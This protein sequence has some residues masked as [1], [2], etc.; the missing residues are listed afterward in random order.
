[1]VRSVYEKLKGQVEK[2]RRGSVFV[3]R[4]FLELGSRAAVDE[5]LS[6][7]IKEAVIR[8]LGRGLYDYPRLQMP[9]DGIPKAR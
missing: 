8:R 2:R 6:R 7:L 4:D 9:R 5:S 3:T 1:M